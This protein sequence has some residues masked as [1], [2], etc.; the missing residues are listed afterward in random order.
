MSNFNEEYQYKVETYFDSMGMGSDLIKELRDK[1][2]FG[3]RKYGEISYQSSRYN[4]MMCDTLQHSIEEV[5]DALNY[6][7]HEMF[8]ADELKDD[9]RSLRVNNLFEYTMNLY[10][11]LHI[12]KDWLR[13]NRE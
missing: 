2:A 5:V 1:R 8:K 3:L 9:E 10:N 11:G 13:D 4:A 7:G 6:L 12:Y